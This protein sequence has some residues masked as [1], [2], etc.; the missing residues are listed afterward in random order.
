MYFRI[1]CLKIDARYGNPL[2]RIQGVGYVNELL[3][4]L[5]G[6]P[7]QDHTTHNSSLEFPLDADVDIEKQT[8]C[9]TC[10]SAASEERERGVEYE[11]ESIESRRRV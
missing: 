4:R 3:A 7:V 10:E 5:T 8:P 9:G 6:E 11:V 2:G 1:C